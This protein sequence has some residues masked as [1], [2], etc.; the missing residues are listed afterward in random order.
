[1]TKIYGYFRYNILLNNKKG[2]SMKLLND[3]KIGQRLNLSIG[4]VLVLVMGSSSI[5]NIMQRKKEII[6]VAS[7]RME[8]QVS[9]LASMVKIEVN[10]ST[11]DIEK[12][13]NIAKKLFESIKS[14]KPDNVN[15]IESLVVENYYVDEVSKIAMGASVSVFEKTNDG[16]IRVSTTV[17]NNGKRSTGTVISNSSQ[18]ARNLIDN[19]TFT[20][21]AIVVN[22]WFITSYFPIINGDEI[23]GA[24]GVGVNEKDMESLNEIF[25]SKQYYES[26]YPFLVDADGSL[27]IHPKSEGV[28]ISSEDFFQ[29]IIAANNNMG[30]LAYD[31]EGKEKI[32]Y[33]NKIELIDSYVAVSIYKD[34]LMGVIK[35]QQMSLI[36]SLI[37]IIALLTLVISIIVRGITIAIN[38]GVIFAEAIANGDLTKTLDIKHNDEIGQLANALNSMVIKIL[39]IVQDIKNGAN[40][41]SSASHQLSSASQQM[42]QGASEQ[43]SSIEEVSSTME[44]ITANISQNTENAQETEKISNQANDGMKVVAERSSNA[45]KANEKIA[46]KITIITDIAFQTNILA[47]NAAVEAARAGEHGKGFAVVA[48]EVRKLAE[49]SKVAAEEII[50]LSGES[51]KLAKSAGAEIS[52]AIPRVERTTGLVKEISAASIEQ[53]NGANEV[54]NAIQQLNTITQQ[55]AASSEELA[56]NAEEL[57]SQAELLSDMIE[58]FRVKSD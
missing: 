38:K 26:G 27:I 10:K 8:E 5:Y 29:K 20:G 17:V 57:S 1:M 48:A 15:L 22:N 32:L 42:S 45:A 19:K 34:E 36:L 12:I 18:V 51:L 30:Q 58:F 49:R 43:A 21:R 39:D 50:S 31:W 4:I 28:N 47:L 40:N 25:L 13:R 46:S 16:F 11:K 24:V 2:D 55:N 9:D 33:Y 35:K 37:V 7:I 56:S 23:V 52:T 54:N 53:N 41:I 44:E 14:N 6:D 3:L